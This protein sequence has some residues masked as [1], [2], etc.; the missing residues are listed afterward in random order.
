MIDTLLHADRVLSEV[1]LSDAVAASGDPHRIAQAQ[2]ELAR[3]AD[4]VASG[5][6]DDAIKHYRK[7]WKKAE[8]ATH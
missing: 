7:A 1:A 6:F 2:R 8:K 3:A 4:E 5:R